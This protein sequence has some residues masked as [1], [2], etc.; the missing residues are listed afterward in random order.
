RPHPPK[1]PGSFVR[2]CGQDGDILGASPNDGGLL[3]KFFRLFQHPHAWGAGQASTTGVTAALLALLATTPVGAA[4]VPATVHPDWTKIELRPAG[5]EPQVSGM[6]FL[7][8]G[9][10]V[11]A[12]WDTVR[13]RGQ[14]VTETARAFSGKVHLL[15]GV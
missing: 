9:R 14:N 6:A 2:L 1:T 10:L 15:S 11:V 7:S 12:H 8:D 3:S 4:T 5:Y 13:S